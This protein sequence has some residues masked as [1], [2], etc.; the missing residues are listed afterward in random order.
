[1]IPVVMAK[2]N[3]PNCLQLYSMLLK[4]SCHVLFHFNL[5][6][7]AVN[8]VHKMRTKVASPIFAKANIE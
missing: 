2:D 5:K 3:A 8:F 7:K 4:Q 6:A 1:M